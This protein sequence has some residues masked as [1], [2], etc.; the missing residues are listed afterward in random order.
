[1]VGYRE[2]KPITK[3]PIV[4]PGEMGLASTRLAGLYDRWSLTG[5][6]EG[7]VMA[8]FARAIQEVRAR[9]SGGKG[10]FR[11]GLPPT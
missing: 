1:M 2:G 5:E 7:E 3:H 10:A 8:E 9:F 11:A 4:L 6:A